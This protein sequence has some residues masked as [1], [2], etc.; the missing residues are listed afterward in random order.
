[1]IFTISRQKKCVETPVRALRQVAFHSKE[2]SLLFFCCTG[3]LLEKCRREPSRKRLG[4]KL[5]IGKEKE[6]AKGKRRKRKKAFHPIRR[7]K[8]YNS[9]FSFW[10]P[11]GKALPKEPVLRCCVRFVGSGR[12]SVG[13]R[14]TVST[15][16]D[17]VCAC[18]DSGS[19]TTRKQSRCCHPLPH[20]RS[21]S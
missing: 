8:L 17:R 16:R 10:V 14:S 21:V 19:L 9:G 20:N 6:D 5:V 7:K 4:M 2:K 3:M 1:M 11:N 15:P 12:R 13:L 18:T